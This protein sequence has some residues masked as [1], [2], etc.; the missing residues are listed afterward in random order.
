MPKVTLIAFSPEP[1]KIVAASARLCYSD[2]TVDGLMEGLDEQK[3]QKFIQMLMDLGHESPIE[4]ASFTFAVEGVSR[5]LLAQITRHR[6]A[7]FSVQSQRYVNLSNPD[8]VIPPEIEKIPEANR[9]YLAA[10]KNAAESYRVLTEILRKKHREDLIEQG[11]DKAKADAQAE[12]L[13][14]EDARFVLPNAACTRM[15]L[16]MNARS[17]MNFFHK[18]CCMRAQWEIR[19]V[20][21]LMLAEVKKQAPSIFRHAGPP[22]I[23]GS[24]PEGKMSCGKTVEMRKLYIGG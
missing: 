9:E 12:K 19:E 1:E 24:C 8:F 13:A 14:L 11:F 23:T 4:H 6:I 3:S 22:C 15:I 21:N 2:Q 20:A 7:S 16:T 17:L 5:S 18:R 10:L